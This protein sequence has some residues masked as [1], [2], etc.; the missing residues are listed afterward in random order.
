M[1]KVLVTGCTGMDGSH[2]VDYLLKNTDYK[3]MGGLRRTSQAILSNLE[4]A[5]KNERFQTVPF[6]LSDVHSISS[7]IQSEKP[8]FIINFAALSFVHDS[9]S[10]PALTMNTNAESLI[11]ILEA[12]RHHVPKCK[13]YSA[14]SS[15]QWGDVLYSP[16]DIK[17]PMRPRSIY[18]VSKC[19]AALICKVYR[20]SYNMFVIHGILTNHES[21]RRQEY[22]VTRKITKGV[23]KIVHALS[24]NTHIPIIT[25]G[26]LDSY[27]DWS[28]SP[29]FIDGIWKM[30]NQKEPKDYILSSGETHSVREFIELAFKFAGIE[31]FFK[32]GD[33]KDLE[34]FVINKFLNKQISE[35]VCVKVDKKFYRPAEVNLLHGDSTPARQELGWVPNVPFKELV[36]RMTLH[37]IEEMNKTSK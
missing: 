30:L 9:W 10:Q 34:V 36:K 4:D 15:E 16:Q 11:H 13:V 27:R 5:L 37:D 2:M 28:Y 6:D 25:M 12:V 23:A 24:N 17:H 8:D 21:E 26:N 19:A 29:D 35:A 3:I 32:K 14:G 18:G 22:F 1:K 33:D 20:E 7:C 31:G